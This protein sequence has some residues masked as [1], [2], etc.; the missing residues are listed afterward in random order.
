MHIYLPIHS[1]KR[2]SIQTIPSQSNGE[3]QEFYSLWH[4]TKFLYFLSVSKFKMQEYNRVRVPLHRFCECTAQPLGWPT[5]KYH[6]W[7]SPLLYKQSMQTRHHLR[8]TSIVKIMFYRGMVCAYSMSWIC[9]W[10]LI[11]PEIWTT[12]NRLPLHLLLAPP[13]RS[14]TVSQLGIMLMIQEPPT[15]QLFSFPAITAIADNCG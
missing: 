3:V 15:Q 9:A 13:N 14:S 6:T 7:L 8:S 10:D 2:G 5:G 1:E 4:E 11:N 12:S